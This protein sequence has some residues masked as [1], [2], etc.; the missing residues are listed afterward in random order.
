MKSKLVHILKKAVPAGAAFV[1]FCSFSVF[2][3]I[4]ANGGNSLAKPLPKVT[5]I[6]IE[7]LKGLLRQNGKP[8]L[9]NFW[10]TWC[11]PCREEFPDLVKLDSQYRGRIDFI[12][13]SLDEVSDI[14]TYVPQFLAEMRSEMPAYLLKTNDD[15]AAI[16][17]VSPDWSGNLPFTILL[18]A[19][20]GSFYVRKGKIRYETV[21]K[22]LEKVLGNV[23][24]ADPAPT[25]AAPAT[26]SEPKPQ[27]AERT[28]AKAT[29][30][31]KKRIPYYRKF[32]KYSKR[33]WAER[34]KYL[35]RIHRKA[36]MK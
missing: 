1:L 17:A 25:P 28:V 6:D 13:V 33:W 3:Q 7:E 18:S 22:E 8:L 16:R 30:A 15:D 19:N 2:G 34:R 35:K 4:N 20:G 29:P 24:P 36:N 12:T 10:A 9:V 23:P 26:N 11:D 31:V 27:I 32:K 14:A 21:L 5:K